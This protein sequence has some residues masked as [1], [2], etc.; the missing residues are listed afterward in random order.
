MKQAEIEQ[1]L[2]GVFQLTLGADT[3]L[4]MLLGLMEELQEPSEQILAELERFF[5]PRRTN[6]PFVPYLTGWT[7][8]GWLLAGSSNGGEAAEMFA[9]GLGRLG[10]LVAEAAFHI[11]WRGTAR[12]LVHFLETATG[13]TGFEVDE[14]VTAD[15]GTRR[16]NHIRV[17]APGA[18]AS[19]R[20]LIDHIVEHEKPAHVT[21]EVTIASDGESAPR[22][23]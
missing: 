3:P 1:L 12:G 11:R 4:N 18:A 13:L 19:Y 20:E 21:H 8:L 15:D 7:G 10:E 17:R 9:P 14:Q 16:P 23:D 2:P 5:D 22:R 6:D